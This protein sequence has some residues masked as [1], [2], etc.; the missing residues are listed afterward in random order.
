MAKPEV[1]IDKKMNLKLLV[2]TETN[3]VV[4]AE[5]G[6]D[7][8]DFLFQLMSLPL[9]TVSKLL[10]DEI[11]MAGCLGTLYKSIQALNPDYYEPNPKAKD[12]VLNPISFFTVPLLSIDE[13]PT[14]LTLYRCPTN[15]HYSLRK[16]EVCTC[17]S[18]TSTTHEFS[19]NIVAGKTT[20]NPG[21]VGF[22]K[23]PVPYIV[24]DNL[25]VKPMSVSL[26]MS[27]VK[28]YESLMEKVVEVGPQQGL[29]LLKASLEKQAALTSVFLRN[30]I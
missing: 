21:D 7:F 18:K 3:K 29:A 15:Y 17:G 28:N 1:E 6:K 25:E 14:S 11:G 13:T 19:F 4:F 16:G 9:S 30:K 22:V 2:D 5:A 10:T 24:M 27:I 12:S 20:L 26:I 23:G 8:V